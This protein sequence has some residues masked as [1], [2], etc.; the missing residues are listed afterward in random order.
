[1][2]CACWQF[3]EIYSSVWKLV[4]KPNVSEEDDEQGEG[5]LLYKTAVKECLTDEL[6]HPSKPLAE[7]QGMVDA[8]D[9]VEYMQNAAL[10]RVPFGEMV[11]SVV[12][13]TE[14]EKGFKAV[15][16]KKP[17]ALKKLSRIVEK[18]SL[19]PEKDGCVASVCDC[20]RMMVPVKKMAHVAH[21][22]RALCDTE[23]VQAI[24]Q[25][26]GIDS[27][28]LVRVKERFFATPSAGGW[29]DLMINFLIVV[30]GIRHV[31]ELQIVH[32]TM[33]SA[34]AGLPGHAIYNRVR[35]ASELVEFV[36]GG[37][38]AADA[39]RLAALRVAL[40][41]ESKDKDSFPTGPDAMSFNNDKLQITCDGEGRV[42]AITLV[43]KQIPSAA[44]HVL[45]GALCDGVWRS[46]SSLP[47]V[48]HVMSEEDVS[49]VIES[50][51]IDKRHL[52]LCGVSETI[53][54]SNKGLT[55]ADVRLV[56]ASARAGAAIAVLNISGNSLKVE[57]AQ[58]M[59]DLLKTNTTLV[60]LDLDRNR[61]GSKGAMHVSEGLKANKTLQTLHLQTN[62]LNQEAAKYLSECLKANSTLQ[63]LNLQSNS[64]NAEGAKYVA[65]ALKINTTL[66]D[67]SFQSNNV[68]NEGAEALGEA[69]KT[70]ST[71]QSLSLFNNAVGAEGA[72]YVAEALKI[73][74]TLK[75]L[76]LQ[77]NPV[78]SEGAEAL[79]AALK[80]NSTLQS[81]D[82]QRGEVGNEGAEALGEALKTNSTLQSLNLLMNDLDTAVKERLK[83]AAARPE[84]EG[85]A[86]P[87]LP[88]AA[89]HS[90]KLELD[91]D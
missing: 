78:G 20:V 86:L 49:H 23:S 61:L 65:G 46:L 87:C 56:A 52:N 73:N 42:T 36:M 14:E 28:S 88:S 64:L 58:M 12:K 13:R 26:L 1:M 81:L 91:E 24:A 2:P 48:G 41:D 17:K 8:T 62:Q 72:K 9:A 29:R 33:L 22:L 90:V 47:L 69:L 3:G 39:L 70:N 79:G 10:V 43:E 66:T 16:C 19:R 53:D 35:N 38:F 71:L 63:T 37:A 55:M 18:V 85:L 84:K 31:C 44:L 32:E 51:V 11:T 77:M 74:T 60:S 76:N 34:R 27:F 82:L 59:G 67:V 15:S 5:V 89:G 80:T 40:A 21:L 30:G 25:T 75:H 68:G 4:D 54:L 45:L 57:G 83:S 6:L 50:R 7:L